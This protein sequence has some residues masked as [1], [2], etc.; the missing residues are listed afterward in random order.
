MAVGQALVACLV[1][2]L[3]L[4]VNVDAGHAATVTPASC[5]QPAVQTA[6]D[7]AQ[8]GDTVVVPTGSCSWSSEVRLSNA[9]G[10]S[11]VCASMGGCLIT[12]SGRAV[13]FDTLAGINSRFYRISGFVFTNTATAFVI[14]I[15]GDGTLER[16]RIDHN[17]FNTAS[18]SIAIFFGHTQAIANYYG[19]IDHN[20]LV[21]S[22]SATFVQIIGAANPAPPA[23]QMGTANNLFVEDNTITIATMTNAGQGCSDMWGNGAMVWRRNSTLNCLVTS[24]GVTHGGGPQNF[25]LYDN[26]LAV[27]AGAVNQ[28]VGDGYRVFHHQGSGEFI[29]FNNRFT[30]FS[31]RN[32]DPLEMTHYRS[33]SPIE[34]GY[35]ATLGRCD[36]TSPRDGNRQ[37][38]STYRGYPCWRQPGRDFAGNL[39]PM[40]AWN[41]HWADTGAK[42]DLLVADP[43]GQSSPSV[44]DHIQPERDYYNAVSGSAQT[45]P[46]APFSGATGMGFGTLA[47]RPTTCTTNGLEAGGGVGYFA[48][49][50]GPQGTLYRC[51]STNTWTTHYQP[52][53]YPHPLVAGTPPPPPPPSPTAP[54][55]VTLSASTL[56]TRDTLLVRVHAVAGR[57]TEPVDAYV[58]V[59]TGTGY[60][61]LQL[62]GRLLPGI[63]P[64]ARAVVI[65][66]ITVPFA[67]PLS[68]APPG[69]YAWLTGVTVPGTLTLRAPIETTPFT[70]SP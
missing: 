38:T 49:D 21:S 46:L 25:E 55:S 62:D 58:V 66:T 6:I 32:A 5:L 34:A 14:W 47:R 35:S 4:A 63:V 69:S 54:L 12:S 33:A 43:W 19:V 39:R 26:A 52:Y 36:G 9:K 40:Y 3:S 37:P 50:Q 2:G 22:G 57:V 11:L 48:T 13:L 64:I 41:N 45:S 1:A 70:I 59:R 28:G 10:V 65:P 53:P 20:T 30:A 16:V 60:L 23:A 27:D 67:F 24:H 42:I 61:S 29:A 31:G 17:R 15:A 56:S 7:Q 68:G 8:D 18:G 44:L 51:G